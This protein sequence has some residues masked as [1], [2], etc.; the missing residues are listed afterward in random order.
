LAFLG[1]ASACQNG[2]D[3]DPETDEML[4]EL[5]EKLTK[6]LRTHHHTATLIVTLQSNQS[7]SVQET[8]NS[9]NM[10]FAEKHRLKCIVGETSHMA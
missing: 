5:R 8:W 1:E 9:S 2:R 3:L 7:T 10:S 6:E 4:T